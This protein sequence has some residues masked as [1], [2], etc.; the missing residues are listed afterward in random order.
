MA[1]TC[2]AGAVMGLLPMPVRAD[3]VI[4]GTTLTI[5]TNKNYND[6]LFIGLNGTATLN[7]QSGGKVSGWFGTVGF[8]AG[9]KGTVNVDGA[10]SEWHDSNKTFIGYTGK[11]TLNVTNGGVVTGNTIS[12]I[13]YQANGVGT[14]TVTGAGSSW[15]TYNLTVGERGTGTLTISDGGTV[16]AVS[17]SST[18]IVGNNAG[19]D[20]TV[21]IGAAYGST[22]KAAGTLDAS[23]FIFRN[24]T[25]TLNFNHTDTDYDFGAGMSGSGTV[26]QIAGV[27]NLTGDSSGFTGTTT[28]SGGT[29]SIGSG[30]TSGLLA[31]D[32]VDNAM[33]VFNRSDDLTVANVISGTGAV[34]QDGGGVTNLTGTNTYSGTTT[35]NGGTLSVN[36]TIAASSGVTVNSGGT[37]GGNGTTSGVTVNAG[38]MLAPG[39]SIGTLNV[40]DITFSAGAIYD[41]EVNSAGQSDLVD[42]TGTAT[43][44]GGTVI[45]VPYPDYA[46]ETTY[47]IVSAASGVIGTFDAANFGGQ[48]LFA[49]PMLTYDANNVF[50]TMTQT[51]A[52]ASAATTPNQIAAAGGAD[53]L[54]S[55][56]AIFDAIGVLG[57]TAD[58]QTAFD[59]VSGE[60]H[61]SANAALLEDSRFPREA[62]MDRLRA[63]LGGKGGDSGAEAEG[64][65]SENLGLWG[66]NFGS[67]GRWDSDGNAA[68][69]DRSIG[70]VL[71]GGDA[72]VW[73]DVRLGALAGYSRSSF[74]IDER[75]SAS[76]AETYT[77]GVYGGGAW[78]GVTLTGGLANSWHNFDTSRA[79]AF[80][81][82]ADDLSASYSARTLQAWG[83]AAASL[84]AGAVRFEPFANLAYVN[85]S[86]DGFT[87]TGGV[88]ALKA[89]SRVVD[90]TF[91]TLGLRAEADL[92]LG[93]TSAT[94][95]GMAG[96]RHD[97][98]GARSSQLAFASGS[99][100]FAIAGVP[101]ARDALLLDVEMD[102]NL[103]QATTL[104]LAWGGQF[105]PG[106]RDHSAKVS[107]NVDF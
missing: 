67:W 1:T 57:T 38:G 53:S 79:V 27:T 66:R 80:T 54:G 7:I 37:L 30:G 22:A 5:T 50:V 81:G 9:S 25:G 12:Y 91:T 4:D 73:Q 88:A 100:S 90:A 23:E 8:K 99:D 31:G 72:S 41:V 44:N 95:R 52:F 47:T 17:D 65:A 93:D 89:A 87:E 58:A 14:A 16:S 45:V 32:I 26:N 35:V 97:F 103:T 56:N 19:S 2:L 102:M 20:G 10:G 101:L 48:S 36:G 46:I 104:G 21:N 86:T 64:S 76:T 84:E 42:A 61:A 71:F 75:M 55:G 40:A 43:I 94:L 49:T 92:T 82:F 51:A 62:A 98:G 68:A 24:G 77:L 63:A 6:F 96:W 29:L 78:G 15:T 74:A 28:I 13:G 85:L 18:V 107:L 60:I 59:T 11:G 33:L 83:E 34:H 3:A 39:N 70:G 106:V 105:G 69:L